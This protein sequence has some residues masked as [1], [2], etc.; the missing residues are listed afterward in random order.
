MVAIDGWIILAD[1]VV[2]VSMIGLSWRVEL[3]QWVH[4]DGSV[5]LFGRVSLFPWFCLLGIPRGFDYSN[6]LG[7]PG[8]FGWPALVGRAIS[9][10]DWFSHVVWVG[11]A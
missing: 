11:I 10:A 2:L 6:E 1:L 9:L 3:T 4:L 7:Y 5:I 8:R